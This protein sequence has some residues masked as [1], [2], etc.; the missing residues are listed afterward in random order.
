MLIQE[1]LS[2]IHSQSLRTRTLAVYQQKWDARS[3]A[4]CASSKLVDYKKD[5]R[6]RVERDEMREGARLE[7]KNTQKRGETRYERHKTKWCEW[8]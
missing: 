6:E 1:K 4:Y 5:R 3:G 2:C 8:V 7:R